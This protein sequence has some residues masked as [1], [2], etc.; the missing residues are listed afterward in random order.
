MKLSFT[1]LTLFAA[2]SPHSANAYCSSILPC[3][4][5]TEAG[6]CSASFNCQWG[7]C[8]VIAGEYICTT[9]CLYSTNGNYCSDLDSPERCA[10]YPRNCEWVGEVTDAPVEENDPEPEPCPVTDD[11]NDI[12]GTNAPGTESTESPDSGFGSGG[13]G[14]ARRLARLAEKQAYHVK[15]IRKLQQGCSS[16]SSA[17][18]MTAPYIA[19]ALAVAAVLGGMIL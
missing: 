2:A 5:I 4:E 15:Q 19:T 18:V 1:A 12:T 17:K 3:N 11:D 16:S 6:H 9:G 8:E 10:R 14:D 7:D 13:G